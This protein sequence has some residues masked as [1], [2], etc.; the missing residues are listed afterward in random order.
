MLVP[1]P[2]PKEF[3]VADDE[4]DV[5][6]DCG[7]RSGFGNENGE[8]ELVEEIVVGAVGALGMSV[9][10]VVKGIEVEGSEKPGVGLEAAAALES[11]VLGGIAK[12][13]VEAFDW[14]GEVSS[15]NFPSAATA[16]TGVSVIVGT[17]NSLVPSSGAAT[18]VG[19]SADFWGGS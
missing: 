14:L 17:D 4:A 15:F 1:V 11:L 10:G 7:T 16:G 9:D 6:V 3:C 5:D 2:F 8:R 19:T 18:L 12:E 13:K